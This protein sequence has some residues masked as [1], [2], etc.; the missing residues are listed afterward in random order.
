MRARLPILLM[1]FSLAAPVSSQET[2]LYGYG[3]HSCNDLVIASRQW[4]DEEEAGALAHLQL[5]EWLS[6]FITALSLA[7]GSDVTRGAGVEGM[8]RE[9]VRYCR[10]HRQ[11]DVFN[12]TMEL[13]KERDGMQ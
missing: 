1:L 5:R 10:E 2:S 13:I 9:V 7:L 4:E 11:G 8:M 3:V 12:A 6:G